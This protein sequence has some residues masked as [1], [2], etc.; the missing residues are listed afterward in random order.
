MRR[1]RPLS[2]RTG[3][4]STPAS[5]GSC[6]CASAHAIEGYTESLDHEIRD[7]GIGARIIEPAYTRTGFGA[8]SAKPDT[9][10][11]A[12]AKQRQ[13]ADRAMAEAVRGGDAPAVVART[14]GTAATAP[15]PKPRY[16]A[17]PPAG[18][19]RVLRPPRPRRGRRWAL[20]NHPR[21]RRL[22]AA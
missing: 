8:D 11:H 20:E 15:K 9:P 5:S 7:H 21:I 1:R 3:P 13:T 19:A 16:T 6:G 17:G 4:S 10:L 22:A 14:I 18:R 12:Y 2:S